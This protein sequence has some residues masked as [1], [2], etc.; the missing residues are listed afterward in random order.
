MSFLRINRFGKVRTELVSANQ[1]KNIAHNDYRYQV[2]VV[3]CDTNTDRKEFIVDHA[4]LHKSV[5]RVF[6]NEMTS[7]EGLVKAIAEE[8]KD[9]CI[10][11]KIHIVDLYV[12]V[13]PIQTMVDASG[14]PL[15]DHAFME[16]S[17][18]GKFI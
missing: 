10:K 9:V 8:V 15:E 6:N 12:K 1:C 14:H 2:S 7:C 4:E 5:Q 11:Q 18:S 17:Q 13:Q 3:C 16:Y